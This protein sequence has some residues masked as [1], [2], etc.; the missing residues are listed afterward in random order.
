MTPPTV[1]GGTWTETILH[2]FT[3]ANGD[4]F[5]PYAGVTLGPGGVLYGTTAAGGSIQ[6]QSCGAGCGI[7]YELVPPSSQGGIWIE[8]IL[9]NFDG[10]DG[11]EPYAG[12]TLGGDGTLYGTTWFGG[13]SNQGTVFSLV[14]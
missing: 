11:N 1:N 3:G 5:K 14:P 9:H 4:G 10:A 13:A 12:V 8:I 2:S 7:V 6:N